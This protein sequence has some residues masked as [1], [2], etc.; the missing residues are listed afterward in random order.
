L[1]RRPS[2]RPAETSSAV[3]PGKGRPRR[4]GSLANLMPLRWAGPFGVRPTVV[5]GSRAT[6]HPRDGMTRPV[7]DSRESLAAVAVSRYGAL[8]GVGPRAPR[9]TDMLVLRYVFWAVSRLLLSLRYRIR[10]HGREMLQ[11]LRGPTL[12]LPN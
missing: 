1:A 9:G 10:V 12:I 8:D 6:R 7:P 4:F 2:R 3:L 5:S 11:G